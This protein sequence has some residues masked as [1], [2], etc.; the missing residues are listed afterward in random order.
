MLSS[1]DFIFFIM[2][3]QWDGITKANGLFQTFIHYITNI[4]FSTSQFKQKKT[5]FTSSFV[6]T[7]LKL[8]VFQVTMFVECSDPVFSLQMLLET[9]VTFSTVVAMLTSESLLTSTDPS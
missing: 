7:S 9:I 4:V 2:R 1:F 5:Q 6:Y 3:L 8:C